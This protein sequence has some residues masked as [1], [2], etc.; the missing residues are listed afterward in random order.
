MRGE[1]YREPVQTYEQALWALLANYGAFD[2]V[3]DPDAPLPPE[4]AIVADIFW[5]NERTLRRDLSK[6]ARWC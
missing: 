6:F 2:W 5:V 4:A 3:D 1:R